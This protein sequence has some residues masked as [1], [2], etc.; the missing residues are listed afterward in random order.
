MTEARP[1]KALLTVFYVFSHLTVNDVA[2]APVFPYSGLMT[3]SATDRR[4]A[5]LA[6]L[7]QQKAGLT[8]DALVE[9]LGITRTAVRQ[10]LAALEREGKVVRGGIRPSGG[11]PQHLYVLTA[12]GGEQFPRRYSWFADLLIGL[13]KSELGG[14]ALRKKL[15]ALG[16]AAA[17]SLRGQASSSEGRL[18][19]RLT[20]LADAMRGL[21]YETDPVPAGRTKEVVAHN[22]IF[23]QVA[24]A[25]PE[26]CAFDLGF[27]A[28]FAGAK[29]EHTECMARGQHVCRFRF[30]EK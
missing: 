8:I 27:M 10:H 3:E 20:A 16:A 11:R 26:V 22:C 19:P 29:I 23:H 21:G 4:S 24:V 30:Q 17:D 15:E 6:A 25:H 9:A 14:E 5:L 2:K 13:L 18:Q 12:S 28:R 7:L 1:A